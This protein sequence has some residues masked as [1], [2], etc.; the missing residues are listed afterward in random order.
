MHPFLWRCCT[1]SS[2]PVVPFPAPAICIY[3][4]KNSFI[5]SKDSSTSAPALLHH[6]PFLFFFAVEEE[7]I[8][9]F[10]AF[11]KHT[12][13]TRWWRRWRGGSNPTGWG[14]GQHFFAAWAN[15]KNG[16]TNFNLLN[17]CLNFFSVSPGDLGPPKPMP[18]PIPMPMSIPFHP[19][20][21][22]QLHPPAAAP[23]SQK[24]VIRIFSSLP[25]CAWEP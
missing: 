24:A 11:L 18:M 10:F 6:P 1:P 22:S 4:R 14:G 23:T 12:N 16:Y 21:F 13:W 19:K 9:F 15:R 2:W 20:S 17:F 8:F 5:Y 7:K 3:S 25:E